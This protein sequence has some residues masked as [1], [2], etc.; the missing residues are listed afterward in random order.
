M[1]SQTA[2]NLFIRGFTQS[3]LSIFL[4]EI[5]D[6]TFIMVMLLANKMNKWL[7]WLFAT[8]AM[9]IMNAVTVSLGALFA[10]YVPKTVVSIVVIA[11]FFAFGLKMLYNGIWHKEGEDGGEDEIEEAKEAIERLEAANE[12][13]DPLLGETA[14]AV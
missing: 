14:A 6:K 2:N 13:K 9:N 1:D 4:A 12:T 5:G 8:I 11:L 10:A 3:F 7:L